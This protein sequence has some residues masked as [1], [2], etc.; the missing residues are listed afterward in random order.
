MISWASPIS[1]VWNKRSGN[2]LKIWRFPVSFHP[3]TGSYK[4]VP[5]HALFQIIFRSLEILFSLCL[6]HCLQYQMKLPPAWTLPGIVDPL[7]EALEIFRPTRKFQEAL[8]DTP[9]FMDLLEDVAQKLWKLH[10]WHGSVVCLLVTVECTLC[11]SP[12]VR[13]RYCRVRIRGMGTRCVCG[14]YWPWTRRAQVYLYVYTPTDDGIVYTT[15]VPTEFH[16]HLYTLV[17]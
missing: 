4:E 1:S 14:R 5:I 8:L 10:C 16:P 6:E 7:L 2:F 11:F 17:F 12:W 15:P 13:E 3:S 9:W